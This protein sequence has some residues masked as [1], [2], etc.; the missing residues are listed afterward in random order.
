MAS[1]MTNSLSIESGAIAVPEPDASGVRV[2]KGIPYAAPPIGPL[3]WRPPEPVVAWTGVR[4]THDF[5]AHPVQGVVWDDIDLGG[6]STSED[7]LNLNIWT[8]AAPGDG[9][10]LPTMV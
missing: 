7:C 2:Y 1:V 5:G 6:A 8:P 9:A 3:R 4:P 10:R